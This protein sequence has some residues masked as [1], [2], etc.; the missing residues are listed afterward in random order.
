MDVT[1]RKKEGFGRLLDSK[2]VLRVLIEIDA[3]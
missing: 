1:I 2:T 3:S